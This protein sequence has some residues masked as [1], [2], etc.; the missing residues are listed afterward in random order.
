MIVGIIPH[1]IADAITY[2]IHKVTLINCEHLIEGTW[3]MKAYSIH[4]VIFKI[5]I[6]LFL[7]EPTFV[8]ESKLQF[9]A[10]TFSMLR[11]ENR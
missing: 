9:I 5:L 11:T 8:T 6:N 1:S 7:S 10:I 4:L 2:I 3:D